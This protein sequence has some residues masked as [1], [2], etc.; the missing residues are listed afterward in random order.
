[1]SRRLGDCATVVFAG[2][3]LAY[4][5]WAK[6]RLDSV[7]EARAASPRTAVHESGDVGSVSNE[8]ITIGSPVAPVTLVMFTDYQCPFCRRFAKESMPRLHRD[9]VGPGK[10]RLLVRELPLSIHTGARRLA[11][12][13]ECAAGLTR[14]IYEF[15][16]QLY[17]DG[18]SDAESRISHAAGVVGLNEEELSR[19]M[20]SAGSAMGI[21][22]DSTA[23]GLLGVRG[24]PAFVLGA[25]NDTIDGLIIRGAPSYASFASVIDSVLMSVSAA[26]RRQRRRHAKPTETGR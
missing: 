18:R 15:Q 6:S 11:N 8:G 21:E 17:G 12:A 13:S 5:W 1:M 20:Q 26:R 4:M 25:T 10:V 2:S 19:C 24:T 7:E 9:Y 22:R 16:Q 23:A 14:R 3:F